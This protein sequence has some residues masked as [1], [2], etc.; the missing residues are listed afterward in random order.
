ME[1]PDLYKLRF[2]AGSMPRHI[3]CDV[4]NHLREA[5]T[6]PPQFSIW[7]RPRA[8][9]FFPAH[10]VVSFQKLFENRYGSDLYPSVSAPKDTFCLAQG[11]LYDIKHNDRVIHTIEIPE[12]TA[13][14]GNSW[15]I[16][17]L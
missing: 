7:G 16:R 15:V 17:F 3:M 5:T 2:W 4:F 8:N 14:N 10:Q 13:S 1:L 6:L 9:D 11:V 12:L